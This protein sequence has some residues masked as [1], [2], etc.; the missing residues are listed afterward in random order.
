MS[1]EKRPVNSGIKD[2]DF[3][4]GKVPMTKAE[5]RAVTLSKLQLKN[6]DIVVDLGAGSGSLSIESA[7]LLTEGSVISV[8]RNPQAIA[9]LKQNREK[10]G[11]KNMKILEMEAPVGLDQIAYADKVIIGGSG[12]HLAELIDWVNQIMPRGG[13][14]VMNMI[15]LENLHI[16]WKTIQ[17]LG[18][19][20]LDLV[21]IVVSRGKGVGSVTMMMGE[22]PVYVI[23]GRK[24]NIHG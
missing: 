19:D 2:S 3:I 18:F 15:T 9:V 24:G 13:R 20:E 7:R 22:N 8:E 12:G 6:S 17:Q 21:Q 10:F 23:S 11:C 1:N 16:G 5:V 14:L 4:R